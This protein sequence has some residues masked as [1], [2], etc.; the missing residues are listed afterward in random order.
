MSKK[1]K[2]LCP[3]TGCYFMTAYEEEWIAHFRIEH[4][5]VDTINLG[6]KRIRIKD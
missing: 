5:E 4:P 1:R 2:M 6:G 3:I